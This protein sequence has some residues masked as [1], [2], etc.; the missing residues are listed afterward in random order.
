MS[1]RQQKYWVYDYETIMNCFTAVFTDYHSDE[2]RTFTIWKGINQLPEFIE[3]LKENV[4]YRDWHFGYNNLAFDAQI[5]QWIIEK[6]KTL[7]A[8]EDAAEVAA[9]IYDYA[10]Y[11]I[12]KSK[13]KE[14]QDYPEWK[15]SIK[16]LD[17]YKINHWD[18]AAKRCSLKWLQ[19]QINW[20][21]VEE[22]P[23]PHDEPIVDMD[24]YNMLMEYNVNDVDSTKKVFLLCKKAIALRVQLQKDYDLPCLNYSNTR[25]GSELLLKLFCL[26]TGQDKK[27]VKASRTFRKSIKLKDVLFPYIEFKD[28]VFQEFHK[29]VQDLVVYNTKGDFKEVVNYKGYEFHYGL[30]GI[31]QCIEKGIYKEDAEYKIIDA[32]VA[33]LY[34]SIAV[35]N[36]MF[37]AHLGTAFYEVYKN[38]IVDV[39]LAEKAKPKEDRNMSIINGFKEAANASYGNSNSE[40]SWLYDSQY[41]MQ[42]TV[43]GQ[44][45]LSMLVEEIML[46]FPDAKLLQTNTD[47]FTF[48]IKRSDE[49]RYYE[50]CRKWESV[51]NLILEY[52]DYS[53]MY[54]WD[55]N[56]YIAVYDSGETKCKGRFAWKEFDD[57]NPMF[58]H[59]NK[60][61]LVVAKAIY[62]YLI[63]G[64]DP[65]EY[66]KTNKNIYDYCAG[67]KL[68]G[69]W[70]F[71]EIK[72]VSGTIERDV[73]KKILR[74]YI[75]NKG[76][77]ILKKHPD[78]R[79]IQ[80]ESGAWQ[81]TIMNEY[82]KKDF[83]EYDINYKYYLDKINA[84]IRS[85]KG[86]KLDCEATQL[87]L[88]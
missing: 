30:G 8:M 57:Y 34:P 62:E 38:D 77:K 58:L 47:G 45:M 18:N 20:F 59:K 10:Q 64:T 14:F 41:T 73:H 1:L 35:V 72:V 55:V 67:V 27:T 78:G 48:K 6:H 31:H 32:D 24:T 70:F 71:E 2:T 50:I 66:L 49:E 37:P 80:L 33:S 79:E 43:N 68:K 17:I 36:K 25:I 52:A 87:T 29:K 56:N 74:Y 23:H 5:T 4:Q 15:L 12:N 54:I 3:F 63:N 19:Y 76:S 44:L 69:Q 7:L 86:G 51:T 28:T 11:V 9:A 39:R 46:E 22:M 75:S 85:I 13:A 26:K 83:D 16:V 61:H 40:Y 81:Q 82:V 84:E 53:A 60:S 21:N 88:F 65:E 42:T